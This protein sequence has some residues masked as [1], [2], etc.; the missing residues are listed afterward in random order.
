MAPEPTH[1]SAQDYPGVMA[2]GDPDGGPQP[3]SP[4]DDGS[5]GFAHPAPG[6]AVDCRLV[7]WQPGAWSMARGFMAK[8]S[9]PNEPHAARVILKDYNSVSF[10]K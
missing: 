9:G 6:P 4:A 8:H 5:R 1:P 10:S 7:A 2:G 3:A